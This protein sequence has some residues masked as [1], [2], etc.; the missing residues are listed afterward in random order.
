[1]NALQRQIILALLNALAE[2]D[3][4][5]MAESL[6]HGAVLETVPCTLSDFE[7]ALRY[8][9]ADPR[10]WILGLRGKLDLMKWAITDSGE[11]ARRELRP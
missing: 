8:A 3:G 4:G 9:E 11:A 2:R 1:M 10:R 7:L 6:L 5:V